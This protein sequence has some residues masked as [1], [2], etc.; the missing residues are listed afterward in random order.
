MCN[1]LCPSAGAPD[2]L[3]QCSSPTHAHH[4]A[5]STWKENLVIHTSLQWELFF[6]IVVLI[7]GAFFRAISPSWLPYTVGLLI[8]FFL[9]GWI[10][11]SV[12]GQTFCPHHAWAYDKKPHD[13]RISP[14]EFADFQGVGFDSQSFCVRGSLDGSIGDIGGGRTCGDG[15]A[16]PAN[17]LYT[18][19]DLDASFKLSSMLTTESER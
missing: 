17:C 1:T 14:E 19:S 4:S 13:G 6:V 5:Y 15:S 2:Y 10:A 11:G 18:F 9:V 3:F 16:S 7:F 8:L 12:E